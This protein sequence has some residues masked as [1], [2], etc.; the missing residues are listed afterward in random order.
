MALGVIYF[1]V[2][3]AGAFGFRVAPTGWRPTGWTPPATPQTMR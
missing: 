3:C 1:V 2:M